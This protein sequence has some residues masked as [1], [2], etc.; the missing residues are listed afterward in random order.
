MKKL[1]VLLLAFL[2]LLTFAACTGGQ[3]QNLSKLLESAILIDAFDFYKE[4]DANIVNFKNNY[5][6]KS[7]IFKDKVAEIQDEYIVV[8]EYNTRI[9]VY[10][11]TEDIAKVT[12][13][14]Y[15]I[16]VGEISNIDLDKGIAGFGYPYVSLDMKDGYIVEQ[17]DE[18][19]EP[20]YNN[21]KS[22]L[23]AKKY[24][25]AIFIFK[26]I[27]GYLDSNNL[28]KE[29]A[30]R[31]S[32]ENAEGKDS[33]KTIFEEAPT[34]ALT[35]EEIKE[36][37]VGKWYAEERS[38]ANSFSSYE[39]DGTYTYG[40]TSNVES[41]WFVENN[42][43]VCESKY[44]RSEKIIYPFYKNAYVICSPK[45]YNDVTADVYEL[46]FLNGPLE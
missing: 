24:A 19:L 25:D 22:L 32:Y 15:V 27:D 4:A 44:T 16:V 7:A 34:E 39:A 33:W 42:R 36:I 13:D 23:E 38:A 21:A 45:A 43:I 26:F 9:K 18:N 37:I 3:G 46:R 29:A 5:D 20:L 6:G 28:L 1:A 40:T 17:S 11:S 10:L 14:E 41:K 30:C 35:N 31:A 12:T 2:M 8:G